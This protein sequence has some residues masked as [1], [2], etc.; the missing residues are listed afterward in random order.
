MALLGLPYHLRRQE[1]SER[2]SRI[3][4]RNDHFSLRIE[5]LCCFSH[6][7]NAADDDKVCFSPLRLDCELEAITHHI[8]ERLDLHRLVVM[9]QNDRVLFS[10]QCTN[11]VF[12]CYVPTTRGFSR[13][14]KSVRMERAAM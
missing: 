14:F 10:L 4:H 5:Y 1:V 2:A 12:Y 8:A 9:H 3:L 11:L 7:L 6:K 13:F